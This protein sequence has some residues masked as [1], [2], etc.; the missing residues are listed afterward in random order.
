V[1]E[2]SLIV[3][4]VVD[5]RRGCHREWSRVSRA[6][7]N[8]AGETTRA[9]ARDDDHTRARVRLDAMSNFALRRITRDSFDV[10]ARANALASSSSR[11]FAFAATPKDFKV[12]P[13]PV[14]ATA[15]GP[16]GR[17][18]WRYAFAHSRS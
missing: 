6:S 13:P 5:G 2:Y 8:D 17:S 11:A 4:P 7:R 16:G 18:S 14:T 9:R 1:I 15:A 10:V 3:V 12:P